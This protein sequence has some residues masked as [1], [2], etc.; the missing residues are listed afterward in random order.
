VCGVKKKNMAGHFLIDPTHLGHIPIESGAMD[1]LTDA[2]V[3]M[4]RDVQGAGW[5]AVIE[6]RPGAYTVTWYGSRDLCGGAA[7]VASWGAS[8]RAAAL[9]SCEAEARRWRA[10]RGL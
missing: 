2:E 5:R 8:S 6:G 1:A 3:V 7:R 10:R 4:R 9:D